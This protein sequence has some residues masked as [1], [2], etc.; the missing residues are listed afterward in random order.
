MAIE[1]EM[2]AS[3]CG[4]GNLL[5]HMSITELLLFI[6]IYLSFTLLRTSITVRL[7]LGYLRRH[8]LRN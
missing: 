4:E 6:I 3:H 7:K 8:Y 5:N 2:S 1:K